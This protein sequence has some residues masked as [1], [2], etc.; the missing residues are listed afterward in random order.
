MRGLVDGTSYSRTCHS[1]QVSPS[2]Q[3][4]NESAKYDMV[5]ESEV[6]MIVCMHAK[7]KINNDMYMY[8]IIICW[9]NAID[10]L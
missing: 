4:D 10:V 2:P 8:I 1:L 5:N 7:K 3:G 9:L 6:N